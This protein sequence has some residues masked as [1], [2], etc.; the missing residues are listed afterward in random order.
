MKDNCDAAIEI[1]RLN[2][3]SAQQVS[4]LYE[5]LGKIDLFRQYTNNDQTSIVLELL[6]KTKLEECDAFSIVFMQGEISAKFYIVLEGEVAVFLDTEKENSVQCPYPELEKNF[7]NNPLFIDQSTH[8]FLKTKVDTLREGQAFGELG[9]LNGKPRLATV[10]A[11]KPCIFGVLSTEDFKATLQPAFLKETEQKTNFFKQL[12][13]NNY[14]IDEIWRLSAFFHRIK[15][16][17]NQ[18]IAFENSEFNR[19]FVIGEGLIQLGKDL[20][21][22]DINAMSYTKFPANLRHHP[23]MQGRKVQPDSKSK[24]NNFKT[25]LQ[26]IQNPKQMMSTNSNIA[27]KSQNELFRQ[28]SRLGLHS[29]PIVIYG[30]NQFIGFKEL[31]ENRS[32]YF[33]TV[34]VIQPGYGYWIPVNNVQRCFADLKNFEDFFME[35]HRDLLQTL[36]VRL[37]EFN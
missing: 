6:A 4:K 17:K 8:R 32:K 21:F 26:Q 20:S 34:K 33:F 30:M 16:E 10:V 23:P 24:R 15:F 35:R 28:S 31:L 37:V 19:I 36:N 3:K 13:D 22:E 5:K 14:H 1:I 7:C 2:D 12:L 27:S 18:V 29:Q 25:F 9:V 11:T